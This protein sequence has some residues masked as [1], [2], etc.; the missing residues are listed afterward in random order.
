ME[1]EINAV[2]DSVFRFW[3]QKDLKEMLFSCMESYLFFMNS[4]ISLTCS[5]NKN[6]GI[7]HLML[8]MLKVRC[9]MA[10]S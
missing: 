6:Q 5:V 7:I 4:N 2:P 3:D 1:K 10:L 8:A 9:S